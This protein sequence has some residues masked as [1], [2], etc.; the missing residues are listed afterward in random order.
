LFAISYYRRHAQ[1]KRLWELFP[2][3]V[4]GMLPGYLFLRYVP[5]EI[6]RPVLG[7]IVLAL[8]LT[9]FVRVGGASAILQRGWFTAAAGVLAGFG[10]AVAN[11][12]GPV[13]SVYLISRKLDKLKFMGTGAWFFFIVNVSKIPF[14]LWIGVMTPATLQFSVLVAAFVVIGAGIGV[15]VLKRIPQ[16]VF[17]M[18]VLLLAGLAA[19]QLILASS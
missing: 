17:N 16:H 13:M 4:V 2:F 10:T 9:H 1:W 19:V 15:L 6:F 14:Y 11:A 5:S 8:L 3:V 18:L 12:A 7:I